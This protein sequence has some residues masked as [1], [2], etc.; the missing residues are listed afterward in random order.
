MFQHRSS[1][2]DPRIS[3]I[4]NHLRAIEQELGGI[5]KNAGRRAAAGASAAGNQIADAIGP[6]LNEIVDRFR[7][8]QRVA[9]DEAADFGS[10]AVKIGAKLGGDAFNRIS[11][12]AKYR[13][14]LTIAIAIGAGVL[15]GLASRRN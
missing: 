4:V 11:R 1:Q 7:R 14:L 13:P 9:V 2:F 6:I 5:G 3:A 15:I 10:E 12:E 8:G